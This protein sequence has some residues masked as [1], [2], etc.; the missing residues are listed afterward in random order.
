M[1]GPTH[2]LCWAGQTRPGFAV[3]GEQD[4]TTGLAAALPSFS[5]EI[6][7]EPIGATFVEGDH[8]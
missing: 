1:G 5:N 2:G 3:H 4:G 8:W 7:A 6:A